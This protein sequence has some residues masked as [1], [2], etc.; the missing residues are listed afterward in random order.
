MLDQ[1]TDRM[2]YVIGAIVIGAAIIAMGL[3]IF[4][5]SFDSVEE[6]YA[7]VIG[8]ADSA[9]DMVGHSENLINPNN[10]IS[11]PLNMSN[12][13]SYDDSENEWSINVK[14]RGN[15]YWSS[16]LTMRY[17]SLIIP[18]GET[19]TI[20]YEIYIPD[21][22]S[23]SDIIVRND[24]NN[25][26]VGGGHQGNDNDDTSKRVFN[27]ITPSDYGGSI[28]LNQSIKSGV[29]SKYW[30]SY[31]N[32]DIVNNPDRKTL[33]DYSYFGVINN[34]DEAFDIKIRNVMGEYRSIPTKYV[35]YE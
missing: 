9:I 24:I 26:Y 18:F 32:D 16:G 2:W 28:G 22:V 5:E 31:T 11:T 12:I 8:V 14:S 6:N 25:G 30:F 10:V 15:L 27:G 21:H 20:S 3:N 33:Y 7:S 4:S 1:N 34:S 13:N 17:N 29:W 23:D 35:P 19:L